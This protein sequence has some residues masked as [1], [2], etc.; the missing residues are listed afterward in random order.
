MLSMTD[1]AVAKVEDFLLE[2][3]NQ[4]KALRV[5]VEGG[6]C[7]GFQYGLA[8]DD[9]HD[10]DSKFEFDGVSVLIDPKTAEY[11]KGASIDFVETLQES[12]FK[13]TNPQAK[14]SCGCGQ[15]FEV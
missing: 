9:V 14:S 8:F 12:G 10:D 3:E 7:S 6:G 13:I 1:K 11:I 2:D 5:F 15:S 4:G